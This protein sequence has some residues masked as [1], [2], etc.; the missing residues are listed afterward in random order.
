MKQYLIEE[1]DSRY[2]RITY[3]IGLKVKHDIVERKTNKI[4]ATY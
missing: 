3:C 2:I 1:I 4:V